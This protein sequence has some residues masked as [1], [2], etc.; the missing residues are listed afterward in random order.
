MSVASQLRCCSNRVRD[1]SHWPIRLVLITITLFSH[2]TA[3]K[4][5]L[6]TRLVKPNST[7][8]RLPLKIKVSS[9]PTDNLD[10]TVR[11]SKLSPR[12]FTVV[13]NE[14]TLIYGGWYL[15]ATCDCGERWMWVN[16]RVH[17]YRMQQVY[18]AVK[19]LHHARGAGVY[20]CYDSQFCMSYETLAKKMVS[21]FNFKQ[22]RHP[23][24]FL[25]HFLVLQN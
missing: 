5:I 9:S 25:R 15:Q 21:T 12:C 19:Y 1:A 2:F 14:L 22:T 23:S 17:A 3:K 8:F 11:P 13:D 7:V 18:N 24:E 20:R 6:L 10:G 4:K 16:C